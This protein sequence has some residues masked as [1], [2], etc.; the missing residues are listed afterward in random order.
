MP[1]RV[2]GINSESKIAGSMTANPRGEKLS[3]G[4]AACGSF[5]RR[6][7]A[8]AALDG[9]HRHDSDGCLELLSVQGKFSTLTWRP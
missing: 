8:P 2:D 5:N 9:T 3:D 7:T 4:I 1:A 6:S